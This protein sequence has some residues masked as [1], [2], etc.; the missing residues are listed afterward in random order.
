MDLVTLVTACA[1]GVEPKLMHALVWHQS[2]GEPWAVS[3]PGEPLPRVYPNMRD[4]IS[5]TRDVSTDG[6]VR[7]GLAG[8]A[9]HPAKVNAAA[10]LPCRNVSLAARHIERLAVRCKAHPHLNSDPTFCAVAVYR[11]SWSD[12]DSKF[13]DAVMASVAKADAPNFDM[14]KNTSM[15]FLDVASETPPRLDAASPESTRL[16]DD[17]ER[18]WSSALF[19]ARAVRPAGALNDTSRDASSADDLRSRR[20]PDAR[21]STEK[22]VVDGPFVARSPERSPQ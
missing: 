10:F 18:G 15:E 9:I 22:P 16:S 21:T 20:A 6:H 4:A 12:P 19:P 3:V 5:E 14:P 17:R 1:L 13:A 11:G 2:G 7:V 8:L